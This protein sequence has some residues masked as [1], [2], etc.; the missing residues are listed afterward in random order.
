[1]LADLNA[2]RAISSYNRI[3]A[4]ILRCDLLILDD[5]GLQTL[6]PASFQDLYE[7]ICELYE[8]GSILVTSNRAFEE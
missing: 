4:S 3:V 1:L 8:T 6:I 2:S 7:I 5:F